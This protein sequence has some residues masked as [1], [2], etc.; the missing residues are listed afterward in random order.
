MKPAGQLDTSLET[1]IA[2]PATPKGIVE[3]LG[4]PSGSQFY[5]CALQVN[6]FQYGQR[7]AKNTGFSSEDDYNEAMAKACRENG[8][9]VVAVTD[10]F[11]FDGSEKLVERLRADGIIVFPGFEA[12]SSEG[13]HILCLFPPET[14]CS[15]MNTHIG[16]CDVRDLKAE[17]PISNKTCEQLMRL[18][19]E[20]GGVAISAH[21]TSAAGML[22]NL[23]GQSR[24][25]AWKSVFHLAAAI[26][27]SVEDVPIEFSQICKNK[28]A[29]HRRSRSIAFVNAADISK[30]D[31]FAKD[32]ATCLVK[33]TDVSI[34]GLKQAFLDAE[35]RILLNS[36]GVPAEYTRLVALAWDRGL[37]GEQSIALNAGL[38]VLIGGRG[39]G[40]STV[41]ESIRYAFG[42]DPKGKEA[43]ATHKAMM[44]ELMGQRASVA[45]LVHSPRPSPGY[46]LVERV[47]GQDPRV[48][49][50]N[51]DIINDL[52]PMD[53]VPGLEVYGQHEISELTRDKSKLAE[54]LKRFVGDDDQVNIAMDSLRARL[55][56]SRGGIAEKRRKIADLDESLAALPGLR[57]KLRRFQA[58]N[59]KEHAEEKT[60]VQA[61]A[62]L[63]EE[64]AGIIAELEAHSKKLQPSRG[65]AEPFLPNETEQKLPHRSTLEPLQK[66]VDEVDKALR[67]AS[68]ALATARRTAE[69]HLEAVKV[70]WEPLRDAANQRFEDIKTKLAEEGHKPDEYVN[71]DDQV[72]RL[73]PKK[74]EKQELEEALAA[75]RQTR[76]GIID[77]WEKADAQAYTELE[78]AA[79]RVSR[80]LKGIV[81]AVIQ[82]SSTIEPL[83]DVFRSHVEGNISQ[84]ISKLEE[85]EALSLSTLAA[86]IRDGAVALMTE[87]GFT[88]ASARKIADAGE[89]LALE[90]EECRIPPEAL[91]E[92]NVGRDGSDNWKRLENLSAGQKATAVLL[93]LLLDADAPLIID[94]PEDDLDNQF[95]AG[96]VVP[97]MRTGKK[98]RQFIFSSHNPNIPVLGDA[99][100][101][102]GLTPTVEEASDRTKV[103]DDD[104]GSID[105]ASVQQLIKDLLEGGE[106]A[107]TTRRTKYGF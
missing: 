87:Y 72:A 92:L 89:A 34:E 94:Q 101:I 12:N 25:N 77:E 15:E 9:K 4:K 55:R 96:R 83:R 73:E 30:P 62:R 52:K 20:L 71:L 79:R 24:M 35:G 47:Y 67:S 102:I 1:L 3:A 60:A 65:E 75:L 103:F 104:C 105:K 54:I 27:G 46:Y 61:E 22:K 82:P 76:Q 91:I 13:V 98:R 59:L 32:G 42:L 63:I 2:H 19:Q 7:H 33:M 44:K 51:G 56:E 78:R 106:Q 38:N 40:K 88:E 66:I 86:R 37:L 57:E 49:D 26:P 69:E 84:A 16:A 10:H 18:V 48:K 97:I 64:A 74:A 99:D 17:S 43:S 14:T 85:K 53:L 58:T 107:F 50:Q 68:D 8:I 45:A 80:R 5:R 39:A 23:S 95:I 21:V 11:R 93:L 70:N 29:Q 90:V 31:D 36:D 28:D 100:Q 6:P 41:V 81:K